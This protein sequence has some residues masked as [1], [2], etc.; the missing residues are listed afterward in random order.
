MVVNYEHYPIR[1]SQVD[2]LCAIAGI[3]KAAASLFSYDILPQQEQQ[4]TLSM[5]TLEQAQSEK[6]LWVAVDVQDEPMGFILMDAVSDWSWVREMGVHPEFGRRGIGRRL[7]E[8][9]IGWSYRQGSRYVGLT[10][11]RDVAWNG[12]FYRRIGFSEFD[13]RTVPSF[14]QGALEQEQ[15]WSQVA[16]VA[17]YME[18]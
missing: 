3:E 10:T 14:L 8:T 18:L 2:D 9:A 4:H 16:R 12:P 6:R 17:M 1:L 13:Q 7:I 11:F 15:S 5:P